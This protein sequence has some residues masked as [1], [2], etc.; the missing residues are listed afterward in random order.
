M[1]CYEDMLFTSSHHGDDLSKDEM[2]SY[3]QAPPTSNS[4]P[5]YT[6]NTPMPCTQHT[7]LTPTRPPPVPLSTPPPYL[8]SPSAFTPPPE[9]YLIG[10][11]DMELL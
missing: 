9:P 6:Q 10:D 11:E 2:D 7:S 8:P 5:I 3:A 4:V 1:A